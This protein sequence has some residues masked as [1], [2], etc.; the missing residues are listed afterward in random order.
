VS[1]GP[2]QFTTMSR[3]PP[4]AC[5]AVTASLTDAVSVTS[6]GT[7]STDSP[8]P[9]AILETAASRASLS[10]ARAATRAPLAWSASAIA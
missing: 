8:S 9:P 2:A 3:R 6:A 10:L 5:A 7:A 1:W 4:Q